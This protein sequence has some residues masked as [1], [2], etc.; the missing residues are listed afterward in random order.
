MNSCY[1]DNFFHEKWGCSGRPSRPASDGPAV[2]PGAMEWAVLL[3]IRPDIPSDPV[4]LLE[5]TVN[6]KS[7]TSSSVQNISSGNV[8]EGSAIKKVVVSVGLRGDS[9]IE[10]LREYL[11]KQGRFGSVWRC[12]IWVW[13]QCG[14][15]EAFF[16]SL[17]DF[18]NCLHPCMSQYFPQVFSRRLPKNVYNQIPEWGVLVP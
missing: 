10:I 6:S 1:N 14:N 18:Q 16:N 4:A 8:D 11:T 3:S 17:T 5:S 12:N 7:R 9:S 2:R 15:L 13:F